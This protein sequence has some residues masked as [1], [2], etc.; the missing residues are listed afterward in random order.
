VQQSQT[1]CLKK[2]KVGRN[3]FLF[4]M[5]VIRILLSGGPVETCKKMDRSCGQLSERL[6]TLQK[7]WKDLEPRINTWEAFFKNSGCSRE[8]G[9]KRLKNLPQFIRNLI[10]DA[11]NKGPKYQKRKRGGGNGYNRGGNRNN[12][13]NRRGGNRRYNNNYGGGYRQNYI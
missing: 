9:E 2:T 8:Y 10:E 12:Y 6:E 11:S 7:K 13:N 1:L 3:I 4:Q 5:T